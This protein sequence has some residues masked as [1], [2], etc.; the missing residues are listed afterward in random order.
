MD[1]FFDNFQIFALVGLA[2]AS[3]LK[4]RMDAKQA[5]EEERNAKR[6]VADQDEMFDPAEMWREAERD[7]PPPTWI[8][9]EPPPV[10]QPVV[11]GPD[12]AVEAALQRQAELDERMREIRTIKAARE[13][14][15]AKPAAQ[16]R[17]AKP[18]PGTGGPKSYPL[19]KAL[20]DRK[21][22]RQAIITR[23]V[24]GPPLGLR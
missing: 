9:V 23:E 21:S 2:L 22:L 14:R 24:L 5:A 1:W 4:A 3:W 10:P 18:A 11:V 19:R 7:T 6:D 15:E 12:P 16:A 13:A 20:G 8:P 17:A